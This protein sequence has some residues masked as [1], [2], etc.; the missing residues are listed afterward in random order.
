[1]TLQSLDFF[2]LTVEAGGLRHLGYC[3]DTYGKPV[4]FRG[5]TQLQ[6]NVA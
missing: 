5:E 2:I 3:K 6:H 1:M 4:S